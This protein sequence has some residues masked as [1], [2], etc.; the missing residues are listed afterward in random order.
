MTEDKFTDDLVNQLQLDRKRYLI[1]TRKSVLYDLSINDKGVVDMGVDTGS[2][3][4]IRGQGKGFQQDILIFEESD[5][6]HT[7]IIPR[8]IV[9]V[10]LNRVTSHDAIV[11]SEKAKRIKRIYPFVRFGLLLAGMQ[12]V[13]GR[14]LRL[15]DNFDF[16]IVV[17]VPPKP[18]EMKSLQEIF[19]DELRA[20]DVLADIL[21]HK[22]RVTSLRKV[23]NVSF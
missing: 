9:E 13:P 23:L 6:G 16:M 2:G 17:S 7:S 3:E 11:Y 20:S 1:D 4:P 21:F 10:K 22:K 19:S 8:L 15:E 18:D 14:V 5:K 12:S